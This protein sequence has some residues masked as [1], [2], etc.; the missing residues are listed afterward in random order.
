MFKTS[1][2]KPMYGV[3]QF[4]GTFFKQDFIRPKKSNIAMGNGPFE[5][6]GSYW[7]RAMGNSIA[8]FFLECTRGPGSSFMRL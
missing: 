3:V 8:M 4:S 2:A 6:A 5:D 1:L 7:Q